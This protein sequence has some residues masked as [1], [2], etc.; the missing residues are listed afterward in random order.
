MSLP[1]FPR[2][3]KKRSLRKFIVYQ[4]D[5]LPVQFIP[6]FSFFFAKLLPIDLL[7]EKIFFGEEEKV[8]K[9]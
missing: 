9:S 7:V 6:I 4:A 2:R 3:K 1:L 5:K 8:L